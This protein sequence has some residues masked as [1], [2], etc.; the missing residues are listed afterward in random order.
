MHHALQQLPPAGS[1]PL[2]PAGD[3]DDQLARRIDALER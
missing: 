3:H 1:P 2:P